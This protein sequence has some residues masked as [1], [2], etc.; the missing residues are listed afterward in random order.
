M[1]RAHLRDLLPVRLV[2]AARRQ[3]L[4]RSSELPVVEV[5]VTNH[6]NLSCKYCNVFAP[7]AEPTFA[8]PDSFDRDIHRLAS[9][10]D[11]IS[12]IGI[13]GGE[14]LLHPRVTSFMRSAR[15]AAPDAGIYMVSNGILLA[16]QPESLWQELAAQRIKLNISDYPLHLDRDALSAQAREH[17]VELEFVGPRE[18]F[19]TFPIRPEGDRDPAHSFETC[20]SLMNC[21]MVAD[22]RLYLCG[23]TGVV[24]VFREASGLDLPV[25]EADYVDIYAEDDPFVI[26]ERLQ[27]PLGWCRYCDVDARAFTDWE[28]GK[29]TP[30]EWM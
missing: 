8:D 27:R 18:Q 19:W 4:G 24:K 30:D 25:T 15:D 26:Q 22:G 6:C 11:R 23:R 13:V 9:L 17:G 12:S 7:L 20:H 1:S 21:P 3:L 14:P 10:F 5:L 29:R 2:A 28:S 16:S